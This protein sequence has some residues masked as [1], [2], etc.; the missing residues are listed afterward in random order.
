MYNRGKMVA[1]I[2]EIK[3]NVKL[4]KSLKKE[5]NGRQNKKD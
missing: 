3:R 5:R 4:V 1:S 2:L